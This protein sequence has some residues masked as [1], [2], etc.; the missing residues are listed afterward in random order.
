MEDLVLPLK[1]ALEQVRRIGFARVQGALPP[2]WRAALLQEI[3]E[4]SFWAL[5]SEIGGVRH[6]VDQ[7][8][9]PCDAGRHPRVAGVAAAVRLA[10]QAAGGAPLADF[11]PNQAV[12]LRYRRRTGGIG[13]HKD[14]KCFRYL[15]CSLTLSGNAPFYLMKG[16]GD[17][18]AAVAWEL[19]PGDLCLL[20]APGLDGCEDGRPWH[21]VGSPRDERVALVLRMNASTAARA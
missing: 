15:V 19:G 18:R 10:V 3:E 20:R 17:S 13:A 1:S 5:P 12:F 16:R 6:G 14:G 8:V 9:L 2:Q 7:L 4:R 21:S 11:A